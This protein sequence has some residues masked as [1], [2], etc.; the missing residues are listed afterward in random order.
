MIADILIPFIVVSLAELGDKTQLS[1][2]F[3]SAKTRRRLDLLSGVVLGFLIVDGLAVLAGSWITGFMKSSLLRVLSGIIFI[4][5]GLL[6]LRSDGE[7]NEGKLRLENPFLSGFL[8]ISMTEWGDKTQIASGLFATEYD[9]LLV[10]IGTMVSLTLLSTVAVYLGKFIS[11]KINRR[12]ITR[13][14]G[15]VFILIGISFF[16]F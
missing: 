4:I 14:G 10:M 15:V 13:I 6:M 7:E 11:N 2:L 8:L 5:F 1:I 12:V 16:L 9:A 3:L